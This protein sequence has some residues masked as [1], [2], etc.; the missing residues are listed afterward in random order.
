MKT[1]LFLLIIAA[2]MSTAIAQD[3]ANMKLRLIS[4]HTDTYAAGAWSTTDSTKYIYN[5]AYA[6]Y[7]AASDAFLFDTSKSHQYIAGIWEL[8]NKYTYVY[9]SAGFET[10]F[11]YFPSG[12][13]TPYTRDVSTYNAANQRTLRIGYE[14]DGTAFKEHDQLVQ[15]YDANNN[16]LSTLSQ[17]WVSGAWQNSRQTLNNYAGSLLELSTRQ[18]WVSGAWLN[19]SREKYSYNGDGTLNNEIAQYWS[20]G[21]WVNQSQDQYL[22]NLAGQIDVQTHLNWT[23]SAW[24]QSWRVN[25]T[26]D[27]AGNKTVIEQSLYSAGTFLPKYKLEVTFNAAGHELTTLTQQYGGGTWQD[28]YRSFKEY[29]ADEYLTYSAEEGNVS[30]IWEGDYRYYYSYETYDDGNVGINNFDQPI[31]IKTYPNPFVVNT[32]LDF[33]NPN[34][35]TVTL[36]VTDITGKKMEEQTAYMP[37]GAQSLIIQ[38]SDWPTGMYFAHISSGAGSSIIKLVKQ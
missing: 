2:S 21:S 35:G 28:L 7:N 11:T 16:L 31:N 26:Y 10:E 18:D 6:G 33:H 32:V 1:Y 19:Y 30:G 13:T 22:Y 34:S 3:V 23:G 8:G 14:W 5:N 24:E 36:T 17:I 9:N 12:T 20:A 29:N 27:G 4:G 38:G 15:M 37:D 25:N